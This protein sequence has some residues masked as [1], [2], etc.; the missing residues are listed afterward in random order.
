[1]TLCY[2]DSEIIQLSYQ[3]RGNQ[4]FLEAT[5]SDVDVTMTHLSSVF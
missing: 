3:K 5:C 2:A 1:M 4:V